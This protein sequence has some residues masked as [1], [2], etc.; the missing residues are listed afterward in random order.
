MKNSRLHSKGKIPVNDIEIYYEAFGDPAN[1]GVILI[2][3]MDDLCTSWLPDFYGPIV[4]SGYYVIRFDNREC[5]LSTWIEAWDKSNPY[6]LEDMALDTLGLMNAL[7]ISKAHFIGASMGGMIAQRIAISFSDRILT[8]T[9]IASSG[10]PADPDPA[11]K[12]T[13]SPGSH[14]SDSISLEEKYPNRET[15][16]KEAVEYRLEALKLFAGSRFPVDEKLQR[17]ILEKNFL[18][19][20]G[21][22]PRAN[23]HQ[24]AAI[25]A[26]ESRFDELEHISVPTL[27]IHGTEDPLLHPGHAV[28]YAGK[29]PD[30]KLVLLEGIGHELPVGI[31][32]TVHREIFELFSRTLRE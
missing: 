24:T 2:T 16:V 25:M 19:R 10:F 11:L 8:L 5:G 9:S 20:R 29:I 6:T 21:Y 32:D 4:G 22:N 3:G 28:K 26:S 15:V 1:P 31:M 30:A 14:I 17:E 13:P 12:T 23:P 18:E 27:V 7:K